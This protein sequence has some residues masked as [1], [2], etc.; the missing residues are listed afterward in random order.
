MNHDLTKEVG[1]LDE[2]SVDAMGRM[3]IVATLTDREA[4]R[5]PGLSVSARVES[6]R[7]ERPESAL[8]VGEVTRVSAVNEITLTQTPANRNCLVL[9]RVIPSAVELSYDAMIDQ[10]R[11]MRETIVALKDR[12]A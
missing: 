5:L 6:F 7:I 10:V 11:R 9:E 8:F 1:T 12:A 3:T 4:M 2:I